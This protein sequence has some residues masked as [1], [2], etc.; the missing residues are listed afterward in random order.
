M[1]ALEK[2]VDGVTCLA[3]AAWQWAKPAYGCATPQGIMRLLKHY[4]L[5]LWRDFTPSWSEEALFWA[6][7]WP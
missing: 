2:D 4:E 5:E 7:P 3:L 6:S 1:I